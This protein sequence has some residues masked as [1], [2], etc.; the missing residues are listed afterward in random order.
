MLEQ[1][2]NGH[3]GTDTEES[4]A[5]AAEH[6][7]ELLYRH[8]Q[9]ISCWDDGTDFPGRLKDLL[10]KYGANDDTAHAASNAKGQSTPG[11]L[12]RNQSRGSSAAP[13]SSGSSDPRAFTA[14]A[15]TMARITASP[16]TTTPTA[17]ATPK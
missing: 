8:N 5:S 13:R 17:T 3:V 15:E 14:A 11:R 4:Y 16:P 12:R 6:V 9:E 1:A 10:R 7:S 2:P